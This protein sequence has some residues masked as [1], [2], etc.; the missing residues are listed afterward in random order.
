MNCC[1]QYCGKCRKN[2]NFVLSDTVK[3]ALSCKV[4]GN[5]HRFTER[6]IDSPVEKVKVS[7]P[8]E[9]SYILELNGRG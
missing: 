4:C 2:T 6:A 3:L 7:K 8:L 1:Y 5:I 9:A